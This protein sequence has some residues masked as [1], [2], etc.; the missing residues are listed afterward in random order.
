MVD[1]V[2]DYRAPTPSAAAEI[3]TPDL[4]DLRAG[5]EGAAQ[6]IRELL[7]DQIEQRGAEVAAMERNLR[8]L[9]PRRR[10][11]DLRQRLDE[12]SAQIEAYQVRHF[13]LLQ[14]RLLARQTAL[15]GANPLALLARGYAIVMRRD[16]GR[17]VRQISDAPAGSR[18][19][20]RLAEGELS[21]Q[22]EDQETH[23]KD[24]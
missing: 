8:H 15:E 6:Q 13:A 11:D 2:A 12:R 4:R 9:S 16:D 10:L 7:N 24:Q 19:S 17:L 21:A 5:V 20:I 23:G 18:I 1:F 3:A 14:E 22:V